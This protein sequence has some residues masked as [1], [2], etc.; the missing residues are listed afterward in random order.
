M[1]F[2][3]K[4]SPFLCRASDLL[5]KISYIAN[6]KLLLVISGILT[7]LTLIFPQ[8][9]FLEWVTLI[10]VGVFLLRRASGRDV[11]G[12]TLYANGFLF[13][14]CYYL[15]CFHWFA[16]LYPLEFI[17]GMT[18][19]AALVVVIVAWFGLSLLQALMGGLVF[20]V[21]K[22]LFLSPVGVRFPILKPFMAAGVWSVYEW[23]QTLGWWGVPWGRL[24][25]G[26]SEYL[27]GLQTASWFGSYFITFMLVAVNLLLAYALM[28]GAKW[29]LGCITAA[30]LLLFQYGAGSAIWFTTDITDGESVRVACIQGN[31][32][33]KEKWDKG[34]MQKTLDVYAEHTEAAANEGAQIVLWPETALPYNLDI[35]ASISEYCSSLADKND[36]YLLVGA[37]VYGEDYESING[38]IC[39]TPEGE[40]LE[41]V[42]SKRHLV[43]FGEYVP[44]KNII[45]ALIPPLAEL[46]MTSDDIAS[47]EGAN[48]IDAGGVAVGGL[49]CFDSIYEELT[50]ESVREGAELICLATNDSWFSDSSALYMH[51]AQAQMRAIES[52]RWIARAA[53]TGISTVITPRGEVKEEL[54]PLVDGRIVYDVYTAER[55]TLWSVIGNSFVY[56]CMLVLVGILAHSIGTKIAIG[57]LK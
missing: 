7:G 54:D 35:S 44:M 40:R 38:L 53:N 1:D 4:Q 8:A 18:P 12:R 34:S 6:G 27:V 32:S 19:F 55:T 37:F 21:I 41:T 51:N 23:T 13:F 28:N 9:G 17:S 42:Y 25:I 14:Y 46:V 45:K 29:K 39:F 47:G 57:K 22:W 26:Q 30:V 52:G 11:K 36:I 31:I 20:V 48:I 24:H 43:P 2:S 49:I 16:F 15:V 10:P 5:R 50:L 33:S 3:K 56:V